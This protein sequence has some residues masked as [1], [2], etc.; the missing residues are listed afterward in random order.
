[1]VRTQGTL[2]TWKKKL[3][4]TGSEKGRSKTVNLGIGKRERERIKKKTN[5]KTAQQQK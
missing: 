1:V 4:G 5:Q 3:E 2:M